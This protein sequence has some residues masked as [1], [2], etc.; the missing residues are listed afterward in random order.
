MLPSI[1]QPT[2]P[3]ARRQSWVLALPGL[4]ILALVIAIFSLLWN[5]HKAE[6]EEQQTTL[7]ADV[8]WL[9]QN[10][11]FSLTG[12]EEQLRA[13]S[14]D[15]DQKPG[16]TDLFRLRAAH[17]AK[18]TPELLQVLWLDDALGVRS[19]V[20][21][22]K[23]P[24]EILADPATL[25]RQI[26]VARRLGKPIY[27]APLNSPSKSTRFFVLVPL[28]AED[29]ITGMLA[30]IYDMD[31]LLRN[32]V[33][34]WFTEKYQV[35]ILDDGGR[36]FAS[37]SNV[38]TGPAEG[39]SYTVNLDAPSGQTRL[40]VTAYKRAGNP[41]QRG[42]VAAILLLSSGVLY[43][44]W[45]IRKLMRRRHETEQALREAHAFRQ[46]MEDS[47]TVGM[48]ARDLTGRITY[49]NSA[50]CRMVGF[51]A[52]ELV[53][54]SPPMPYWVPEEIEATRAI[55]DDVLAGQAPREGIE[56]HLMR[57]GGERFDALIY[58][59]PLIDAAGQQTGWMAS[60]LDVTERKRAEEL[61][62][63]QQEKI[64][65]TSRLVTMGEM[66]STLAHEL[67]QPL[68]AIASYAAGCLNRLEAENLSPTE[69]KPPLTKLAA[70]AQRA[71]QIIRRVHDFVRRSEPKRGPCDLN[72]IIEDALGLLEAT[73][74]KRG[75]RIRSDLDPN[76]PTALADRV[77]IE[78]VALNLMRNGLDAMTEGGHQ[79]RE[80]VVSTHSEGQEV[81]LSVA[82]S[83]SGIGPDV[84]DKL[85]SPFFSTKAE[86]MGMGLNIC[87][88]IA[89]LHRG[90]LWFEPN[91]PR[92]TIF[93]LSLPQE[94]K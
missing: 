57:K 73:A 37:K 45:S 11:R 77:M 64:Q 39:P 84:A 41:A 85:F 18:N 59:A 20:P 70:Q 91:L 82:D 62:R 87:R 40:M 74:K 63:Q 15:L 4:G 24:E 3:S 34:W 68:S 6:R 47:L 89:E 48:R 50:F 61:Y 69:L 46:A 31:A 22:A 54:L 76:L 2:L 67:N 75:A 17:L 80:L 43:S 26:D 86:G 13:L 56:I 42:L 92:G 36:V 16:S 55:H 27:S 12:I 1:P 72:A 49:V 21:S 81:H 83:G 30:G 29:R 71:G 94:G 44:L 9:E 23:L 60:V 66:A 5:Q 58:E 14:L 19:G 93:H 25:P 78:Q 28:Y 88:S 33:P 38:V 52:D 53:G 90:R 10:I 51:S 79:E 65:F 7:I 32:H 35:R 8:L